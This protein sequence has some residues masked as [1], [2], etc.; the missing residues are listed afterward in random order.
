MNGRGIDGETGD[1]EREGRV[2]IT[3]S[4]CTSLHSAK[5]RITQGNELDCMYFITFITLIV[6]FVVTDLYIKLL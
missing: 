6:C 4:V 5:Q 1:G 3:R 2:R